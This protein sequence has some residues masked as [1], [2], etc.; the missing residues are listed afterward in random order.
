MRGLPAQPLQE[1][2]M[3]QKFD[4]RVDSEVGRLRGVLLHQ[5][6]QEVA[7]MTPETAERA[8]YSD[9][10]NLAVANEEYKQLR[11]VLD[12]RCRVFQV[13]DLLSDILANSRVRSGLVR[14]ICEAEGVPDIAEDLLELQPGD[15]ARVMI[16]GAPLVK[17]NLSRFLS[18]DRYSLPPLHNFFFTRDSAVVVRDRV[19]ISRMANRVRGRETRIVEAIFDY[20]PLFNASTVNPARLGGG[21][22]E[23]TLE[24]GDVLVAAQDILVIGIGQRTSCKAVDFLIERVKDLGIRQHIVVQSLPENPESFIHLDMVFT[25]LDRNACLVYEPVIMQTH[26]FDTVHIHVEGGKVVSIREE[27]TVLAALAKLGLDLEPVFCGGRGDR[28]TQER[29]QWH[30][31][32]NFFALGPGQVIGY[33]R[34]THTLEELGAAGFE[35]VAA[36]DVISGKADLDGMGRCVVTIDG[37]ELARGGG[38]CRCM[39]MPLGREPL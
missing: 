22:A 27:D 33:R 38:G 13:A 9:I 24:G 3:D 20:H 12:R 26:H 1:E 17:D 5:P 6:G 2:L 39:T 4:I 35:V 19:L 32:A 11:G 34:N 21:G 15:L 14:R 8:L 10:L 16:E 23:V 7:N 18:K 30:S 28:W 37:S 29:E 36:A 31:G 25:L